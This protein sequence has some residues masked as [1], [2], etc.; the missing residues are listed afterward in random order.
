MP[1]ICNGIAACCLK[2]GGKWK[3]HANS[4]NGWNRVDTGLPEESVEC[5]PFIY[6]ESVSE[7]GMSLSFIG[8]GYE[9]NRKLYLYRIHDFLRNPFVERVA[10]SECG[11]CF[12]NFTVLCGRNGPIYVYRDSCTRVVAI[13]GAVHYYRISSMPDNPNSLVVSWQDMS[14]NMLT[15]VVNPESRK[16][17][18]LR[19]GGGF[20]Y[21]PVVYGGMCYHAVRCGEGFEDR[22]IEEGVPELVECPFD[23]V[24]SVE[25]IQASPMESFD[26]E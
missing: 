14:G 1:F 3:V 21:K 18:E 8:G 16:A 13:T 6:A 10:E 11:F 19:C 17:W 4:G 20:A 23:N 12:K 7:G 24:A 2:T 22:R 15:H 9:S 26:F 5:S 25:T